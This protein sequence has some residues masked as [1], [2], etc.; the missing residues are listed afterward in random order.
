MIADQSNS[1]FVSAASIWEIAI[2]NG[3]PKGNEDD[4]LVSSKEAIDLFGQAG[5][6]LLSI[7]SAHASAV[8]DLPKTHKDPFDR[9]IVA[10]GITEPLRLVTHDK[11]VASYSASFLLV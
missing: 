11:V 9:L 6:Q 7:T 3:S 1:L 10:Q 2:K 5:F 8:G 4:M